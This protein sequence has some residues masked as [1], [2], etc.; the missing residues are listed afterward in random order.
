MYILFLQSLH[1]A[2]LKQEAQC[3]TWGSHGGDYIL[4]YDVLIV[5]YVLSNVLEEPVTSIFGAEE[6]RD[7][8]ND[9][10]IREG[11]QRTTRFALLSWWW[12]QQIR[13]KHF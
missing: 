1:M 7:W 2:Q 3:E 13:P 6:S 5:W 10:D 12:R 4:Q 11:P 8:K 9:T